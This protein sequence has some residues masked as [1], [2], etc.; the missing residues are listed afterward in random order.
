MRE[1]VIIALSGALGSV[2]RYLVS[3]WAY[4]IFGE[5]FAYGTIAVNIIGCF[6]L[7]VAME[8]SLVTD[9]LPRTL[10]LAVTIGFLGAFTTYSTFGY[11]T[12]QYMENGA[13][14]PVLLNVVGHVV[15][16]IAAVWAGLVLGRSVFGGV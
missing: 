14:W 5:R 2:S 3:G 10:R 12:Y 9:L 11:E 7:G 6:A 1:V 8:M 16:G 15:F 4:R 13:W